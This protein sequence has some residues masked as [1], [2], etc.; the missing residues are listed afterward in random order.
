M[1]NMISKV[2]QL[3]VYL[4]SICGLA[5]FKNEDFFQKLTFKLFALK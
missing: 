3:N 2:R 4:R 1:Y 5:Y